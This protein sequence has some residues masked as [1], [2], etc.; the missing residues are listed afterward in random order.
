M[1]ATETIDDTQHPSE[2]RQELRTGR[3]AKDANPKTA[4]RR[5]I[6]IIKHCGYGNGS[7]HVAVD[8]ACMQSRAGYEVTFV[9]AGGT[10]EMLLTQYGVH[11]VTLRHDQNK[12]FSMLST[13][14]KLT[15]F[16]RRNRADVFHAHMMSSTLVGYMA[17]KLSGVPLVTTVH[18]S[19]DQHSFLMRLGRKVVAVSEAERDHLLSQGYS[20]DQL[21]AVINAPNN[22]PREAFMHNER[23]LSIQSPC[24][25]TVCG[26]HRRK[27]VFDLITACVEPLKELRNWTLYIAGEGPDRDELE[28]QARSAGIADRVVFLGFL[29]A[30]RFLLE[31]VDIFVLAS[32]A[33]PF[34]LSLAEARA[35]GCAIVATNVGGIPEVLEFGA[36]GR[37]VSPG[38]PEQLSAELRILMTNE[39]ARVQLR[40]ASS[41]GAEVF[42]VNRLVGDYERVYE[43]ARA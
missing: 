12:P 22:S 30:P 36:A 26:L 25:A 10:F 24:I 6:H 16:A 31:K 11:H 17:S 19:F 18:N 21:C 3:A 1:C 15:R 29:P 37:L 33:E 20:S 14:W 40:D 9:S 23:E 7:V 42:D 2:D 27:G 4:V 35:A 5:V 8:L 43:Q 34:G 32:Y 38:K 28:Q 41:N 13:A 39:D